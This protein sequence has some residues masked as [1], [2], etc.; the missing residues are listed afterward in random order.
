MFLLWLSWLRTWHS[1]HE[2]MGL[3][4][5]LSQWVNDPTLPQAAVQVTDVAQIQYCCDCGVSLSCSSDSAPSLGTSICH[6]CECKKK[7]ILQR[8]REF[9]GGLAVK[10]PVL[11][12][13]WCGFYPWPGNFFWHA[14]DMAR[15]KKRNF[16]A[17]G[18]LAKWTQQNSYWRQARVIRYWGWGMRNLIRYQE[19]ESG[20]FC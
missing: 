14:V 3:I 2:D 4:P 10:D 17:R 13:L 5:G 19:W 6:M 11:S 7:K 9:P 20:E 12:L 1:L 16:T 8:G 18:I 15:K